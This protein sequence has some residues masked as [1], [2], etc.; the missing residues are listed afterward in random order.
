MRDAPLPHRHDAVRIA[1]SE[2]DV[3]QHQHH[4]LAQL[5]GRAA[6]GAH[7]GPR[8]LH[9]QAVQGVVQQHVARVLA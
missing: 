3:V 8:M 7:H 1:G 6:Q 9:V 5:I 4:R 2:V